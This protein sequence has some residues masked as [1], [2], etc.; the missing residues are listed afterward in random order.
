MFGELIEAFAPAATMPVAR[1][2]RGEAGLL[3]GD[4]GAAAQILEAHRHQRLGTRLAVLLPRMSHDQQLVRHDLAI[5]AA[6]PMRPTVRIAHAAA[7]LSADAQFARALRNRVAARR[8]PFREM[9]L[10]GEAAPHKID[11]RIEDAGQN[12]G[13]GAGFAHDAAPKLV[14]DYPARAFSIAA[15]S[16]FF[17]VIIACM[18]RLAFSGSL[19]LTESRRTVGAICHE[20]PYL[21]FNQ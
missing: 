20:R 5:G 9:L 10:L 4:F 6:E 13:I 21:S 18:A 15:M 16:I 7:P 8:R 19:S 1:R 17:I 11:R 3:Q 12:K 2:L 14:R